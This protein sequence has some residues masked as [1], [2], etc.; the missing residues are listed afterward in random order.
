MITSIPDALTQCK[1]VDAVLHQSERAALVSSEQVSPCLAW[2]FYMK[3]GVCRTLPVFNV[4]Q[5]LDAA[6]R[7]NADDSKAVEEA[8][9]HLPY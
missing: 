1:W 9:K 4:A 6:E 7:D 8:L 5:A 2:L 3:N